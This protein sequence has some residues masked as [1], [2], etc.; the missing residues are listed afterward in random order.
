MLKITCIA[1]VLAFSLANTQPEK[2]PTTQ[3]QTDGTNTGKRA[4]F[5]A[6]LDDLVDP[7]IVYDP[8]Y[9]KIEFP[10]GDVPADIG[11]CSDVVIRAFM[12]I[13]VCLQKDVYTFRKS[14]GQAI[15]TNIDHR[16]VRNL[17]PYFASLGWEIPAVNDRS[18]NDYYQPGDIIWWKL[19]SGLDH[20]GVVTANGYVLH[21]IGYGQVADV[22]PMA[23]TVHKVY[24]MT[25]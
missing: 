17:G 20:I 23:Y 12:N 22:K 16:R 13:D 19:P 9:L 18:N 24:R 11:V 4:R 8:A 7:N 5:V 15:D 6:L 2:I 1:I 14:K 25:D 21:N 3:T 10:C